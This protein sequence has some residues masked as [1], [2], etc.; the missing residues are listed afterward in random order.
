GP[1]GV[2]PLPGNR[3]QVVWTAPHAEAKAVQQMDEKEF[4]TLLEK[5]T[6]GLLGRLELESDR[7][8][9]PVQLMQSDRY[10][11]PR[12]ALIGDAAHCCHPVGGQ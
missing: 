11:L 7:F 6:G 4:L 3:C 2:L 1:M 12:L 9:F 10:V 5:R 8:L